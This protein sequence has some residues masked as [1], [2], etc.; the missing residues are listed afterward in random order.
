MANFFADILEK[1]KQITP[2]GQIGATSGN[3]FQDIA[4]RFNLTKPIEAVQPKPQVAPTKAPP[5]G[6]DV[7]NIAKDVARSFPR[8][9]AGV[10]I[11]AI[12][13]ITGKKGLKI[14]PGAGETILGPKAE[15][16]V[17]GEKP[18]ESTT[19]Q[20]QE[21]LE[22]I[23]VP[24]EIAKKGG[25]PIGLTFLGLDI[26]P[27]GPGKKK[28]A[29]EL[30]EEIPDA[31]KPLAQEARKFKSAEELIKNF[32]L[33]I[34]EKPKYLYKGIGGGNVQAQMLI[35]GLHAADNPN[36]AAEFASRTKGIPNIDVLELSPRAKIADLDQVK[37]FLAEKK[38]FANTENI[39][40]ALKD[41]GYDGA[42]G[43]LPGKGNEYIIINKRMLKDTNILRENVAD[44][45]NQAVKEV[46]PAVEVLEKTLPGLKAVKV[47]EES[48]KALGKVIDEVT[49]DLAKV[50]GKPLTHEEVVEAAK[51]SDILRK[52]TPRES[53][54]QAEAALLKAKQN[55]AALA[56]GETV[57]S[58]FIE[59]LK[60]VSSKASDLGRQ[61]E[62]LKI[63]AD[64][65]LFTLKSQ[66]IKKLADLGIETDK[67]L[68]AAKGVDFNNAKQATEFYRKFVKP[69]FS[70]L[71]DEYRY[72]N[73]L[74]SP[75]THIV[76][77]FS[78]ILQATALNPSVKL[79]SGG[80][81]FIYSGLRRSERLH[82][83]S[84]VPAYYK[85]VF[86]S[87][88]DAISKAFRV[89]R[90][91]ELVYRPDLSTIPTGTKLLA[92]FQFIPRLLEASDVFFRTLIEAG[93]KEALAL[94]YSKQGTFVDEAVQ[95]SIDQIA[96]SKAEYY[97]FRQALDPSNKSGQGIVLSAIDDFTNKVYGLRNVK[98]L[99]IKWFIPFV[100]T[101]MNIL[102]QGLEFSPLGITTLAK[103]TNKIEQVAKAT[104][105]S[106]VFM[107][108]GYIAA[109]G[110][111]TWAL[112]RDKKERDYF[113][114]SGRQPY[115]LKIGNKWYS[116]A[117]LGP[118]AYPIALAAAVKY[119]TE[120][121]PKA[122]TQETLEKIGGILAGLAG[123]FADQS[124][125]EGLG[126]F[127]D[128]ARGD[129][130]AIGRAAAQI[131]S[132]LIPLASLQR[133]IADMVDPV[134]RKTQKGISVE[135]ILQNLQKGIP[136][137]S[138]GIP[139]VIEPLPAF[140]TPRRE[141]ERKQFPAVRALSPIRVT[142][143]N[144]KYE[145]LYQLLLKRRERSARVNQ[146]KEDLRKRLGL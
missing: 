135:A 87:T 39:T 101:P 107:G 120:D 102:K 130:E 25:L 117:R 143:E 44:F 109:K 84:E 119:Y 134:F 92:P 72:I 99:P 33:E 60:T 52:G 28:L 69:T 51:T 112:P 18:I 122:A 116:Y 71:I 21:F 142:Q 83:V 29:K 48:A 68:E 62:S 41:A 88:S 16:F 140:K 47:T 63:E 37:K 5:S 58:E 64:P 129:E 78:N 23:G 105:G 53:T 40:K 56:K 133:W 96:R 80:I 89:I 22:S 73:L 61:L 76:N 82:Y 79:V 26:L 46:K 104:V 139:G 17:F 138:K 59:A 1:T 91:Q 32:D 136:G 50:K 145:D 9:G 125:V 123:F 67:I 66:M 2:T 94:K 118:L 31:L 11:E 126:N 115:S 24:T 15:K 98:F 106:M 7:L 75:L 8:E 27:G 113:Y 42:V 10:A 12:E 128:A 110:D 121:N 146:L 108:A 95:S 100:Q 85:G 14:T 3:F 137:L 49:P 54:L 19:K 141:I 57:T 34:K 30:L 77:A 38:I 93:E 13:R 43:T 70:E 45:Y 4:E 55:L 81:D 74:S 127:I 144:K 35:K 97:V 86:N 131:P 36:V 6:V 20:G 90:G 65:E 103:N 111:S 124:Y 132:Q 114:A